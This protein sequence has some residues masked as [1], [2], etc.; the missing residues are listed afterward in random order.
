MTSITGT[1]PKHHLTT[2]VRLPSGVLVDV[3]TID[4]SIHELPHLVGMETCLFWTWPDTNEQDNLAVA[5]YP[6]WDD[7]AAGHAAWTNP[8][9][10][11]AVIALVVMTRDWA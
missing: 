8:T 2:T 10:L 3:S 5:E 4:L 6:S 11:E 7:A 9:V 1:P